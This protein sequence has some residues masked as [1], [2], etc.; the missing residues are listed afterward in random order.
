MPI[1]LYTKVGTQC[2]ELK[3]ANSALHY[4]KIAKSSTGFNWLWVKAGMSHLLG[5]R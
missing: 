4:S 5:G 1:V 3:T 2:D